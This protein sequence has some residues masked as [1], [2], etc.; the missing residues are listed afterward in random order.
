MT[1]HRIFTCIAAGLASLFFSGCGGQHPGQF[2]GY[3]EGEYIFV[4]APLGGALTNLAVAR[5]DHVSSGQ[6]LFELEHESEAASLRQ[7]EKNLIQSQAQLDNLTKGRRPTE[8]ASLQAQLERARSSLATAQSEFARREK[9]RGGP[10]VISAEELD[11]A[12][13]V[14]D[15]NLAEVSQLTADIETAKLGAREDELRAGQANVEAQAAAV[16]KARWALDQKRQMAPAA[17]A[18]HDT[19]Y[20][21]GEWVEPGRPVVVLLPP[22]NLKARFF[23]PEP[24]MSRVKSG[25]SVQLRCDGEGRVYSATVSYISNEAEF[26]PPML[27]NRENRAKLVFMVEAR[28]SPGEVALHPGQPLDVELK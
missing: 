24:Q 14:R 16:A 7:A 27:Y 20:R 10:E 28:F 19:L 4:A 22:G 26:T 5:G 8:I 13:G 21:Q 6:L 11:S 2:Q 25:Q 1:K 15:A 9:L 3:V 17:S 23:V 18:V 12:R